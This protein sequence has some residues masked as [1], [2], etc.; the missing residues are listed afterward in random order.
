MNKI[1][2]LGFVFVLLFATAFAGQDYLTFSSP[3]ME[4]DKPF[5]FTY[6]E[7]QAPLLKRFS[8]TALNIGG[9]EAEIT[10]IKCRTLIKFFGTEN[11]C[12]EV[13]FSNAT[14]GPSQSKDLAPD[15][16]LK[17]EEEYPEPVMVSLSIYYSDIVRSHR[18]FVQPIK[19][20]S[21]QFSIK[22]QGPERCV[23]REGM[24][25]KELFSW[26]WSDITEDTCFVGEDEYYCDST[27]SLIS[28][29]NKLLDEEIITE[30]AGGYCIDNDAIPASGASA[31]RGAVAGTLVTTG[32][33]GT[34]APDLVGS[35]VPSDDLTVTGT[36][37]VLGQ[38]YLLADGFSND[39]FN[40]FKNY[41]VEESF[42]EVP[43][44]WN[45][46]LNGLNDSLLVERNDTRPGKY[47]L[48]F[49]SATKVG[50]EI[51]QIISFEFISDPNCNGRCS[52]FYGIPFNGSLGDTDEE[53]EGYGTMFGYTAG[54]GSALAITGATAH[55]GVLT[56]GS[57]AVAIED[58]FETIM[59]QNFSSKILEI[60]S[61]KLR[62]NPNNALPIVLKTTNQS[63]G[64]EG[65]YLLRDNTGRTLTDE[66]P[67]RTWTLLMDEAPCAGNETEASDGSCLLDVESEGAR[68]I[69]VVN[70]SSSLLYATVL[71]SPIGENVSLRPVCPA[72]SR[73]LNYIGQ[74]APFD[75]TASSA[76]RVESFEDLFENVHAGKV[77][78]R[79]G[80]IETY[81][82]D[83]E[84]LISQLRTVA[85]EQGTGLSHCFFAD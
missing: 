78:A 50:G 22:L 16:T 9:E 49:S 83:E 71:Y 20:H 25:P 45:D 74:N 23:I 75:L 56:T 67:M 43:T 79:F 30:C 11:H 46:L 13:V 7:G 17:F 52:Q 10:D 80:S 12:D 26:D 63:N 38:V 47:A 28:V 81:E 65:Y 61:K 85:E 37:E 66:V 5:K 72:S 6:F 62:F 58:A 68:G 57:H 76:N 40:D 44:E 69:K 29:L 59:Q 73:F 3:G 51:V 55:G 53:R 34:T 14:V 60:S 2:L 77:C 21:E 70:T 36:T 82:W 48:K 4:E 24:L 64:H 32:T 54:S 41:Y 39:F 15:I 33:L 84:A 42:L 35:E 18:F 8:L 19:L 27:Q 1:L 31:T